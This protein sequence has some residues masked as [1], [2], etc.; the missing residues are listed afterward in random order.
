MISDGFIPKKWYA[1]KGNINQCHEIENNLTKG[2]NNENITEN[3][4][5]LNSLQN[6]WLILATSVSLKKLG[7]SVQQCKYIVLKKHLC[8]HV[9]MYASVR[10]CIQRN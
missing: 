8:M 5:R 10:T 9:L 7:I 3:I 6:W 4:P 2:P 1:S